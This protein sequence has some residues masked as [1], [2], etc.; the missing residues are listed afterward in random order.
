MQNMLVERQGVYC[1]A[2]SDICF[3]HIKGNLHA[4][5]RRRLNCVL[6]V[7]LA[8]ISLRYSGIV[9]R[10]CRARSWHIQDDV[11]RVG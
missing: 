8:L 3:D 7:C 5:L 6:H 11:S 2:I 10:L 9:D 1:W 4:Q